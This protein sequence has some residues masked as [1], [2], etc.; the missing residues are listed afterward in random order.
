MNYFQLLKAFYDGLELNQLNTS[1]IALWH[2]L[3]FTNN[4]VAWSATFTV[5]S[6][7]LCQKAG[8]KSANFYKTR[9]TL[10]Q[11]GYIEWEPQGANRAAKY[12]LID[13][14]NRVSPHSVD[15]SR[16]TSIDTGRDSSRGTSRA[17]NNLT[18]LNLDNDDGELLIPRV[19]DLIIEFQNEFRRQLVPFEIETIK[20]WTDQYTNEQIETELHKAI[21]N[22]VLKLGYIQSCLVN[23]HKAK[24]PAPPGPNIPLFKITEE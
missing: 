7:V 5:A 8:L 18:E 15:S 10:A 11:K 20:Q 9:N 21:L 16:D 6:S 1:E 3:A 17:L 4:K 23:A 19:R 13:L 22:N 12:H 2:A 24:K 14:T